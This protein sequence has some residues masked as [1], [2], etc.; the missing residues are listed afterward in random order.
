MLNPYVHYICNLEYDEKL[1]PHITLLINEY[2]F[3]AY[4]A[5]KWLYKEN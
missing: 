5:S 1:L 2:S 3:A 4:I